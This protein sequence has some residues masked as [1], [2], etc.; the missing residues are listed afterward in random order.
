VVE[1]MPMDDGDDNVDAVEKQPGS[2]N[3]RQGSEMP[4]S[5]QLIDSI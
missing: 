4:A 2:C 3:K 1:N 5:S